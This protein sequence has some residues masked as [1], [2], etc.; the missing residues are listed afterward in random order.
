MLKRAGLDR[1]LVYQALLVLRARSPLPSLPPFSFLAPLTL[2]ERWLRVSE[3]NHLH[4]PSRSKLGPRRVT[5]HFWLSW[6]LGNTERTKIYFSS[7]FLTL[8]GH[9]FSSSAFCLVVNEANL[10]H[11]LDWFRPL[12]LRLLTTIAS[13]GQLAHLLPMIRYPPLSY[14]I[15]KLC[16]TKTELGAL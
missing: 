3:G 9:R 14:L 15:P 4:A 5:C 16:Q 11:S 13:K 10:C 6:P 1:R 2:L 12:R 7:N 8:P